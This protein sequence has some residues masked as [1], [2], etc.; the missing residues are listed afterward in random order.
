MIEPIVVHKLCHRD[1]GDSTDAFWNAVDEAMP[2]YGERKEWLNE[3]SAGLEIWTARIVTR[4]GTAG[5]C[6]YRFIA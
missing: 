4:P 2:D 1:Q 3:N 5:G 6:P